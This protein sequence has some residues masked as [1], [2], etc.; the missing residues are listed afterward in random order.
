M[1]LLGELA[2][3]YVKAHVVH[4]TAQPELWRMNDEL[5]SSVDYSHTSKKIITDLPT[6]SLWHIAIAVLC[7]V[8]LEQTEKAV[9][10]FRIHERFIATPSCNAVLR[11]PWPLREIK[12]ETLQLFHP[13][14]GKPFLIKRCLLRTHPII[15]LQIGFITHG[16]VNVTM[17]LL[18]GCLIVTD[19]CSSERDVR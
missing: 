9:P 17:L 19:G 7:L 1:I 12:A 16:N 14:V 18:V 10:F 2:R 6:S 8:L 15:E 11:R 13:L 3:P 4:K 5:R